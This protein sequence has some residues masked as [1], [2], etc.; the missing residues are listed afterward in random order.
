[1]NRNVEIEMAEI[2]RDI[3][4]NGRAANQTELENEFEF[5]ASEAGWTD[6]EIQAAI[7]SPWFSQI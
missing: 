7:E 5:S 3:I 6:E 4:E 2:V 1:M